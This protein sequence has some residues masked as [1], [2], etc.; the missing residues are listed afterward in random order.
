MHST[1]K[2]HHVK[3]SVVKIKTGTKHFPPRWT[4]QITTLESHVHSF[5]LAHKLSYKPAYTINTILKPK[6]SSLPHHRTSVKI[7]GHVDMCRIR[8]SGIEK[9]LYCQKQSPK[10]HQCFYQQ[11]VKIPNR[12]CKLLSTKYTYTNTTDQVPSFWHS[13]VYLK[14]QFLQVYTQALLLS[15]P[16]VCLHSG[17]FKSTEKTGQ[18]LTYPEVQ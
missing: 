11:H 17:G 7:A 2:I 6:I 5:L 14:K 12:Q 18:A 9:T 3:H 15:D 16:T 8:H 10:A 1:F 13:F 4:D